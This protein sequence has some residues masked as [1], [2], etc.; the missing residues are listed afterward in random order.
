[1]SGERFM[2]ELYAC[3]KCGWWGADPRSR[4]WANLRCQ[5]PR[6]DLPACDGTMKRGTFILVEVE[7]R[8]TTRKGTEHG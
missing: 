6:R 4:D 1:M 2:Q 3:D 7:G 5:T 8:A